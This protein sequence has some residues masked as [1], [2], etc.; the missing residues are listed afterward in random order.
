[1]GSFGSDLLADQALAKV[2][3]SLLLGGLVGLE[4]EWH[5]RA[6]G[7][8]TH[9]MVCLGAVILVI[10]SRAAG[11]S[12]A[13][14]GAA[15]RLVFDPNRIAAGIVTGIGFLGAG[16]ILRMG[17]LIRG[18]TTAACIWFVAALG[19]VIGAGMFGLAVFATLIALLVLVALDLI[20]HHITPL[21]YRSLAVTVERGRWDELEADCLARLQGAGMRVQEVLRRVDGTSGTVELIFHI[22]ARSGVSTREL[23]QEIV[24]QAG[25]LSVQWGHK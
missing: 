15:G 22:R 4:R 20:E 7:L 14:V 6:A 5:G 9:V 24:S 8:R 18:L 3:L 11:E 17:D 25:V 2:L 23:I 16:A 19:I 13:A 1:M 12:P 21:I 10:G